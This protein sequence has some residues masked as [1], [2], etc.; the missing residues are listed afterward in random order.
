MASIGLVSFALTVA[1]VE[2][3][4]RGDAKVATPWT[5]GSGGFPERLVTLFRFPCPT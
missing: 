3:Q 5:A 4:R 2:R 1:G